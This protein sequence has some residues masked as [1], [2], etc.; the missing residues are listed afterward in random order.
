[1]ADKSAI[2]TTPGPHSPTRTF[3]MIKALTVG[4][5]QT[6]HILKILTE[7]GFLIEYIESK[8]L[9]IETV[10][11]FYHE[12]VHAM[13]FRNLAKSV[14]VDNLDDHRPGAAP[15]H[16]PVVAMILRHRD[17]NVDT[18]KAWRELIGATKS[19]EAPL[20]SLREMF[21][22]HNYLGSSAMVAD[23]AVHGS[24]S[25]KNAEFEINVIF[26]QR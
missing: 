4:R 1:M 18:I 8:Q 23:N 9:C 13:Y 19:Y 20:G 26:N 10:K 12:H 15:P 22:G 25:S 21:G 5:N 3:A 24:D 7:K 2:E 6:L 16:M 14:G 11:A 17:P